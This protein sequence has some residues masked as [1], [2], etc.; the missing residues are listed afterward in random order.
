MSM[1]VPR[2]T[3]RDTVQSR[4]WLWAMARGSRSRALSP[5][6][7]S[8]NRTRKVTSMSA[9]TFSP[10]ACWDNLAGVC[11]AIA[12][13]LDL[14]TGDLCRAAFSAESPAAG[15]RAL[16]DAIWDQAI[17]LSDVDPE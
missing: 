16:F 11:Y 7:P 17:V 8:G 10:S 5:S 15:A 13:E 3:V 4:S 12:N 2:R 9:R 14:S 1:G 6:G